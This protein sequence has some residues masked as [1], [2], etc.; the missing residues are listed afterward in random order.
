MIEEDPYAKMIDPNPDN[1][2]LDIAVS[3]EGRTI[4]N[5]EEISD[6]EFDRRLLAGRINEACVEQ[7]RIRP[8][9]P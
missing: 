5:G 7:K 2:V 6:E 4:W 8:E 1:C 3:P 9:S